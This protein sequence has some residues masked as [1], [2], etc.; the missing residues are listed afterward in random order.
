MRNS[1]LV[2]LTR[3]RASPDPR[4]IFHPC[5]SYATNRGNGLW[6]FTNI[7]LSLSLSLSLSVCLSFARYISDASRLLRIPRRGIPR[8]R[9]TT[10]SNQM[11]YHVTLSPRATCRD[12][13]PLPSLAATLSRIGE[14]ISSTT[15]LPLRTTNGGTLLELG[16]CSLGIPPLMNPP[17]TRR[18]LK[19]AGLLS[20]VASE[21]CQ[22]LTLSTLR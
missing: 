22:I 15:K 7:S 21:D 16:Y 20:N 17:R 18:S 1:L 8:P 3:R 10:S 19:H 9:R 13:P 11:H 4:F 12:C 2:N 5:P 14:H 6:D